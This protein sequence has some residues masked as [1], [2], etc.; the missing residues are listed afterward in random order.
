MVN[1]VRAYWENERGAQLAD[2]FACRGFQR[3]L[4]FF[5]WYYVICKYVG[6]ID[7]NLEAKIPSI[8]VI[9]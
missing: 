6:F 7:C 4:L 9:K 2:N 5:L 3:R 8:S 1:G